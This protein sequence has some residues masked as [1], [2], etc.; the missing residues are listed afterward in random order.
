MHR[1][2]TVHRQERRRRC[3]NLTTG[4]DR[5]TDA[6]LECE[7]IT[8]FDL[9]THTDRQTDIHRQTDGY[10]DSQAER[11]ATWHSADAVYSTTREQ[12]DTD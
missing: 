7:C 10:T 3:R 8:L 2:E 1:S 12:T 4:D 6:L 11:Q 5:Q 9:Q